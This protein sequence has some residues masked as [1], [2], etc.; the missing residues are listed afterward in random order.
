MISS[1]IFKR[2]PNVFEQMYFESSLNVFWIEVYAVLTII[3]FFVMHLSLVLFLVQC[4]KAIDV[5]GQQGA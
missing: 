3:Q 2:H 4:E 5:L 1:G